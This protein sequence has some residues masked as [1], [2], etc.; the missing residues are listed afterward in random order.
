MITKSCSFSLK[1]IFDVSAVLFSNCLSCNYLK[2][3]KASLSQFLCDMIKSSMVLLGNC[4]EATRFRCLSQSEMILQKNDT[5]F[6]KFYFLTFL[7]IFVVFLLYVFNFRPSFLFINSQHNYNR[8]EAKS[9]CKSKNW[10]FSLMVIL[11]NTS[12]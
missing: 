12:E 5:N 11:F 1:G 2:L 9:L 6:N 3:L 4:W 7:I 10:L 8:L